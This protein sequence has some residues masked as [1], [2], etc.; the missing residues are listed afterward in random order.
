VITR[1][2]VHNST[3]CHSDTPS[4]FSST[5]WRGDEVRARA[6]TRDPR[7]GQLAHALQRRTGMTPLPA[8]DLVQRRGRVLRVAVARDRG[9]RSPYPTEWVAGEL[10][11]LVIA[12]AEPR[13][14]A[15]AM[16]AAR[17][18]RLDYIVVPDLIALLDALATGA[19][20]AILGA[21]FDTLGADRLLG[22][23]RAAG[24]RIPAVVVAADMPPALVSRATA[25]APLELLVAPPG[26]TV[27]DAP[28]TRWLEACVELAV[29]S[30]RRPGGAR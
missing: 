28:R 26:G 15:W 18:A 25:F 21:E 10:A 19:S 5:P 17:R 29:G 4:V 13:L 16:I 7:R 6:A 9:R 2:T 30:A 8:H 27:A 14:R 11:P 12:I 3:R 22:F 20:A 23:V 1:I 24:C